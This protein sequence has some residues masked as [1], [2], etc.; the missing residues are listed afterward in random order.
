MTT[1][2]GTRNP[3]ETLSMN[4]QPQRRR[5]KRLAGMPL[6]DFPT[7]FGMRL[8]F[9]RCVTE[10]PANDNVA[11]DQEDGDF[12]YTRGSKR[13]RTEPAAPQPSPA[14]VPVRTKQGKTN[15]DEPKAQIGKPVRPEMAFST[16]TRDDGSF[17]LSKR[18]TR[19]STRSSIDQTRNARDNVGGARHYEADL[20][21]TDLIGASATE[22]DNRADMQGSKESLKIA[23]P[24]SD[25]PIINRNKELRRKGTGGRRSSLGLRGRRASSLIDMGHSA[26]PHQQVESSQFYKHIEAEGLSE[27]R[28]MKQLLI[29]CGE[30]I[31]GAKQSHNIQDSAAILAGNIETP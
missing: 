12:K 22:E 31:L 10:H 16:P 24:F 15:D 14:L 29:W 30:R 19:R 17:R 13:S 5:S 27:P 28:R 6:L 3:L 26:I 7:I 23:L 9:E 2:V 21:S 20:D 1:L 4:Q 18:K 11:Y 25:T 8:E